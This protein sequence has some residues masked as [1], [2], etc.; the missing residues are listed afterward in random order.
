MIVWRNWI[1]RKPVNHR[2]SPP[3]YELYYCDGWF[4]FG[5]IP[6]YIRRKKAGA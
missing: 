2:N 6:L 1:E 4:L 3:G 5:V